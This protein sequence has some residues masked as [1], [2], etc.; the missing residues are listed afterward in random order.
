MFPMR[1]ALLLTLSLGLAAHSFALPRYAARY[2]Q[3]CHLCHFNPSGGGERSTYASQ[4]LVPMEMVLRPFEQDELQKIMPTL[5]ENVV[6]GADL[7]TIASYSDDETARSRNNFFH[8]QSDIYL[9]FQVDEKFALYFDRGSGNTYE[10]FGL[11]RLLP[12]NGYIKTGRFTPAYGWKLADHNAFSREKLGFLPPAHTDVGVELGLFPGSGS[13]QFGLVNGN[14]GGTSDTNDELSFVVRGEFRRNFRGVGMAIGG[15]LQRN[16]DRPG[17]AFP[18]ETRQ[19]G[20]PFG[21]LMWRKLTWLGEVDWLHQSPPG[22]A[23]DTTALV[24]SHEIAFQVMPGLDL[25]GTYSFYD[26][27][28]DLETGIEERWAWGVDLFYN[29]FVKLS[30]LVQSYHYEEGAG[31]I[32]ED[33]RQLVAQAHFLY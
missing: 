1:A 17:S 27:D 26:P 31:V 29:P 30:A 23:P 11:A 7:R 13:L 32:G 8:M 2:E 24:A 19:T 9:S 10:A 3:D 18:T 4:Y 20:G 14:Q 16:D 25:V 12:F 28:I 15:A 21:Y 5:G 22:E 33:Y 6:I